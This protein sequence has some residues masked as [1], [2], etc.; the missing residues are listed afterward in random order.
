[1]N[2]QL[3]QTSLAAINI[4][5][6]SKENKNATILAT[7][8]DEPH[9]TRGMPIWIDP[10]DSEDKIPDEAALFANGLVMIMFA[11]T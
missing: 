6:K 10:T 1:M 11:F 4:Q 9:E 7:G 3:L 8:L 2:H 5:T